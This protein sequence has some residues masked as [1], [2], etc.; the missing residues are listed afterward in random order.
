M[1]SKDD[2]AER[3]RIGAGIRRVARGDIAAGGST[4]ITLQYNVPVST[5]GF[6]T[7]TYATAQNGATVYN[8]PGPGPYPGA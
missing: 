3:I 6:M 2:V 1:I 8:Y 5:T 4:A 7:T